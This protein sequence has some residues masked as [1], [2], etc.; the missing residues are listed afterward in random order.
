MI[1]LVSNFE[2]SLTKEC[3]FIRR[4]ACVIMSPTLEGEL[5]KGGQLPL[6][7]TLIHRE[8]ED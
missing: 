1:E 7:V 3:K 4:E 6:K 8:D 5:E 2:F